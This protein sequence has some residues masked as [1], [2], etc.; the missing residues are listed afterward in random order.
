MT[1]VQVLPREYVQLKWQTSRYFC[2]SDT[3]TTSSG[4]L[5]SVA[6]GRLE[7]SWIME[8]RNKVNIDLKYH[9]PILIGAKK[10]K[11]SNHANQGLN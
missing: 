8:N 7:Q 1:N 10:A 2:L 11:L 3:P 6:L 9:V 5:M 4:I